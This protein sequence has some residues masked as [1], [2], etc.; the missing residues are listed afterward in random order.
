MMQ[1]ICPVCDQGHEAR[2]LLQRV[3]FLGE[4]PG[5]HECDLLSE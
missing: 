2:P 4:G 3:P 1:R 5:V